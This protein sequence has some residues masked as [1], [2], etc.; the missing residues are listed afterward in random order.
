[1]TIN[2][3]VIP[4]THVFPAVISLASRVRNVDLVTFHIFVTKSLKKELSDT[5]RSNPQVA[6]LLF[7]G[8]L[9]SFL[10]SFPIL[11]MTSIYP[12]CMMR[13]WIV[14]RGGKY[15]QAAHFT[16]KKFTE[17][18]RVLFT[19]H[20]TAKLEEEPFSDYERGIMAHDSYFSSPLS[21]SC[22]QEDISTY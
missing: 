2:A 12:W 16:Q 21:I 1:M 17:N 8:R 6:N 11:L 13:S 19:V 9:S 7:Y 4:F 5:L 15:A 18:L 22:N 20:E 14:S 3:N 10:P